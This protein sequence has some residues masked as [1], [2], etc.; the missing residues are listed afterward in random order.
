MNF[1][2]QKRAIYKKLAWAVEHPTVGVLLRKAMDKKFK[3]AEAAKQTVFEVRRKKDDVLVTTTESQVE[4]MELVSKAIASK[5]AS[6]Y[7]TPVTK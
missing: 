1:R 3:Q 5:K 6:L 7:V 4:A 2:K